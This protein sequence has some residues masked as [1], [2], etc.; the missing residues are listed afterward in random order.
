MRKK[1]TQP[2]VS[3]A[4][5]A[6][7][8]SDVQNV[9]GIDEQVQNCRDYAQSRG[10]S[11]IDKHIYSDHDVIGTAKCGTHLLRLLD[12]GLKK[13]MPF[14]YI[15]VDDTSRLARDVVLT[16]QILRRLKLNGV[17]ICAIGQDLDT[18]RSSTDEIL[19]INGMTDAKFLRQFRGS[20]VGK[21]R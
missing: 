3:C 14:Q 12:S 8:F 11:I 21:T 2:Q 20:A 15:L 16:V 9:K 10:W 5:Y 6:R 13:M 7:Y 17:F 19:A 18:A 4:V 1:H